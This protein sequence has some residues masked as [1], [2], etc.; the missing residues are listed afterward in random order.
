[1]CGRLNDQEGWG[2]GVTGKKIKEGG[3]TDKNLG[4]A[5]DSS[6]VQ[7]GLGGRSKS[8]ENNPALGFGVR[9]KVIRNN[10]TFWEKSFFQ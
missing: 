1:V 3:M 5:C 6:K 8:F 10:Q 7:E 9:S 2:W 4:R